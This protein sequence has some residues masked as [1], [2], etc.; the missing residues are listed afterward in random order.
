MR[1]R[2]AHRNRKRILAQQKV[3]IEPRRFMRNPDVAWEEWLNKLLPTMLDEK[4]SLVAR[5][6]K[7]RD[8]LLP[9]HRVPLPRRMFVPTPIPHGYVSSVQMDEGQRRAIRRIDRTIQESIYKGDYPKSRFF[10]IVDELDFPCEPK[11]TKELIY[12]DKWT[13]FR[14]LT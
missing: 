3:K 12:G 13:A 6:L 5:F 2:K 1:W 9:T 4:N 7:S 11:P 8:D 14:R 10:I